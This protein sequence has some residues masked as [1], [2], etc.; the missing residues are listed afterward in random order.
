LWSYRKVSYTFFQSPHLLTPSSGKSTLISTILRLLDINSGTILVDD[1]DLSTLPRDTIRSRFITIPQDAFLLSGTLRFNLDPT[2]SL[3]DATIVE[4]LENLGLWNL[5][6][7]R[8]GLDIDIKSQPLSQGQNQILFLARAMLGKGG[9][10]RGILILDEPTSNVDLE[11]GQLIRRVIEK[12]FK[13]YT[14]IVISHRLDTIEE[15]DMI[16][17]MDQGKMVAFDSPKKLLGEDEFKVLMG[18]H[19]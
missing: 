16:C 15:C 7:S 19:E 6:A 11:T 5:L 13:G 1:I 10:E 18:V 17:V 8:G 4:S 3:P 12:E 14:T 9:K 2:H